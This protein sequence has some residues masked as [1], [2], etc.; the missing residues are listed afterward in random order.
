METELIHNSTLRVYLSLTEDTPGKNLEVS[1]LFLNNTK[2]NT[3]TVE[4]STS[5]WLEFSVAPAINFW[6]RK[7]MHR[8]YWNDEFT[9]F[10]IQLTH[11]GNPANCDNRMKIKTETSGDY[12]PLLTVYSY[13]TEESKSL[14]IQIVDEVMENAQ[15]QQLINKRMVTRDAGDCKHCQKKTLTIQTALLNTAG[16]KTILGPS[17]IEINT[18]GGI[19]QGPPIRS[20]HSSLLYVLH[21]KSYTDFNSQKYLKRCVPVEYNKIIVLIKN[22]DKNGEFILESVG[23]ISVKECGCVY[24]HQTPSEC[25]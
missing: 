14:F 18:C 11:N 23:N 4:T 2:I 20:A 13:E 7:N 5:Q 19:C 12:L 3:K 16:K 8:S 10:K 17:E 25:T 21:E 9:G 24:V 22:D 15:V 6:V 1:L